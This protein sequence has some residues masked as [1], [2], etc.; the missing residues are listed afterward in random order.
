SPCRLRASH[1]KSGLVL[2][3]SKAVDKTTP[4]VAVGWRWAAPDPGRGPGIAVL[5]GDLRRQVD[6]V[7]VGT[8]RAGERLAAEEPPPAFPQVERRGARGEGNGVD[9][10]REPPPLLDRPAGMAGESVA[11]QVEGALGGGR[12]NLVE[13]LEVADGVAQ[14]CGEGELVALAHAQRA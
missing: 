2:H 8:G 11:D 10:W 4:P 14:G 12:S 1:D 5:R 13:E 3:S 9:P 7:G 6:R